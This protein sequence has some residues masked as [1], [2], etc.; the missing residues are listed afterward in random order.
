MCDDFTDSDGGL[1]GKVATKGAPRRV[2][3]KSHGLATFLPFSR[4]KG[5]TP[6]IP[7]PRTSTRSIRPLLGIAIGLGIATAIIAQTTA[8]RSQTTA[9]TTTP[10]AADP[11]RSAAAFRQLATV[12]RHPR[13]MN[14]HTATDFPRQG[15]ERRRHDQFVQ[16]GPDDHGV[17]AMQCSTCHREV[18]QRTNGVPGAPGWGLAPL[19]MAWE[20]LDDAQLA[21]QLKNQ[22]RNG[23]RS[24]EE[25][26]DH[27]AHDELVGW[28][29][30][31][32]GNRQTP[33]LSREEFA[34]AFREWIDTGAVSPK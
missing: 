15:D 1:H 13:C 17:P 3:R 8:S 16:R 26:Y 21:D 4:S 14:C 5:R 31:P 28:G 6:I 7:V 9:P 29:W 24:L 30:K 33:P 25:I 19:S 27:I 2:T 32:G 11:A 20:G 10:S 34:R 12:L 22:K 18:N 23:S